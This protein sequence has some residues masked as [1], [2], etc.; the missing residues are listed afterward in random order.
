VQSAHFQHLS[1]AE[2]GAARLS[3]TSS[4]P[5]LLAVRCILFLVTFIQMLW[6]HAPT[7]VAVVEHEHGGLMKHQSEHH[8]M[9]FFAIV[10]AVAFGVLQPKPFPAFRRSINLLPEKVLILWCELRH[11]NQVLKVVPRD[12]RTLPPVDEAH[13]N[14]GLSVVLKRFLPN[15][16]EQVF[17][18]GERFLGAALKSSQLVVH[19]VIGGNGVTF[20]TVSC[21]ACWLRLSAEVRSSLGLASLDLLSHALGRH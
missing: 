6:S 2:Y 20:E 7:V 15:F 18:Y 21:S 19:K 17:G 11:R 3:S 5:S 12:D 13:P 4:V 8:T 16:V 10:G 9:G 1:L 14:D